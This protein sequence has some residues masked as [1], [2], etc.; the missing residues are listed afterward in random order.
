LWEAKEPTI[1]MTA[2]AYSKFLQGLHDSK[3]LNSDQFRALCE[4]AE[5]GPSDARYLGQELLRR[6]WMTPY[7][8]N[9][10]NR[11][12]A[13]LLTLGPYLLLERLGRG[14]MGEVLKARHVRLCRLAALKVVRADRRANR[15]A[16]A[17]FEREMQTAARLDHPHIV[18][19]YDAE[20]LGDTLYLAMQYLEGTDL[21][22]LVQSKGPLPV[23]AACEYARQTACGLQHA[24]ERRVV[25]RDVK[26]SNLFLTAR[27]QVIKILDM[28]LARIEDDDGGLT[29]PNM[30]L[31]TADFLSPEQ[32]RDARTADVRSDL[33]GL[34][35]TL[36]YLLTGL[37]PFSEGTSVQR[38]L[39][40]LKE[41][42]Q[43][44]EVRRPD[45]PADLASLVRKLMAK[46]PKDRCQ[47]PADVAQNLA[48]LLESGKAAGDWPG[49]RGESLGGPDG[50]TVAE[51]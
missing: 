48:D 14:G 36:Y 4:H 12:Q 7:Q 3:A 32:I 18:H 35:C 37:P 1:A 6:G 51:P 47:T 40:H 16:F 50:S 9:Q 25:H 26:P 41:E 33:Y 38:M 22:R 2:Q 15:R 24:F 49:Q 11:G 44:V 21:K 5:S 20:I 46:R 31:G 27:G 17:R 29:Q 45:V 28:G 19:A 13:R 10:V 39:A 23:A 34:G 43:P 30:K 8:I 42:A